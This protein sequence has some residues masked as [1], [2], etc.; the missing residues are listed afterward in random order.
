MIT[1]LYVDDDAQLLEIGKLFLERLGNISVDIALS[2]HQA[3]A[4]LEHRPYDVI[5]S[6]Y[7]MP[8]MDG[9]ELLKTI[10]E[11]YEAI[12][13]ILFTG[14]GREELVI[15]ALNNGADSYLQKGG[16]VHAQFVELKNM[17][18]KH[19][20]RREAEIALEISEKKYRLLVDNA[21]EGICVLQQE[22]VVFHNLKFID[23]FQNAGLLPYEILTRSVFDFTHPEDQEFMRERFYHRITNG[24]KFDRYPFRMIDTQGSAHWFE[25]DA[26]ITEWNGSPATLNFLRDITEQQNLKLI[27]DQSKNRYRELVDSLPKT[28]LEMDENLNLT[29]INKAGTEKF[30][31][32]AEDL[33]NSVSVLNLV[34]FSD[35]EKIL[36]HNKVEFN[37]ESP[38][39]HEYTA[40]NKDG[41]TFPIKTYLSPIFRDYKFAGFRAVCIDITEEKMAKSA[42]E[43]SNKKLN[44]MTNITRHDILNK[45]TAL[46]ALQDLSR[47]LTNDPNLLKY[48]EKQQ[49]VTKIIEG[50]IEFT[51]YYQEIG[52]GTP[53]WQNIKEL[54]VSAI[55]ENNIGIISIEVNSNDWLIYADPLLKK[56]FTNIIENSIRHGVH[57]TKICF[58]VEETGEGLTVR[59]CDDGIGIPTEMKDRVFEDGYGN[60]TGFG[61][62]FIRE[63]LS[64]TGLF[65]QECGVERKGVRFEI[66][67]PAGK[68][69]KGR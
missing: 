59:Y 16:D 32:D 6:D 65:I 48:L 24:E 37:G 23:L 58:S 38:H 68:F 1:A 47:E 49:Q 5:I 11:R 60:H 7:E 30:G 21:L 36:L 40:Q 3:I 9:I 43:Q 17:I 27:L 25:V 42:L 45:V 51:R 64:I 54:F 66:M 62:F 4:M 15:K 57:V 8:R 33:K 14:R 2:G 20:E 18:Q 29:F 39:P 50:H 19:V 61:L 53:H 52:K 41:H 63:I 69:R 44:L 26:V 22:M 12:P 13:F 67:V 10:R 31:Y 34:I 55:S 46:Y 56:V 35:R 28:I